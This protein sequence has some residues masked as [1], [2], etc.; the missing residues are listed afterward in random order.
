[1]KWYR[2]VISVFGY[3]SIIIELEFCGSCL[4]IKLVVAIFV[5]FYGMMTYQFKWCTNHS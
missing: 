3:A 5:E 2:L 4:S 1:M